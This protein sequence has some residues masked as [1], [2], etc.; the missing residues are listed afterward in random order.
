MVH[1]APQSA[2]TPQ[3]IKKSEPVK[4]GS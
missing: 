4:R 1:K 3:V 2:K